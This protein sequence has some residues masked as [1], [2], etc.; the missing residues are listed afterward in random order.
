MHSIKRPC[1]LVPFFLLLIGG[2]ASAATPCQAQQQNG[3]SGTTIKKKGKR[4]GPAVSELRSQARRLRR[5]VKHDWPRR[6]L[7]ATKCLPDITPRTLYYSTSTRMAYTE[8][9]ADALDETE[10]AIAH[11]SEALRIRPHYDKARE[12]REWALKVRRMSVSPRR[13]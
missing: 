8:E 6:W 4:S 9:Q 13:Q 1:V 2:I 10:R 3:Q 11:Y 12:N 7:K 5:F